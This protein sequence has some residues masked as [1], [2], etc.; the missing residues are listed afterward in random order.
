MAGLL[1]V[2]ELDGQMITESL[3]IMQVLLLL[4]LTTIVCRVS[5]KQFLLFGMG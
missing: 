5:H 3:V 4:F 2:I 1:P